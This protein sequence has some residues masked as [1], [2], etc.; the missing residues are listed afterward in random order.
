MEGQGAIH[1]DHKDYEVARGA[2]VYLGPSE[3]ATFRAA[4]GAS[5]KLFH[6]VVAQIPR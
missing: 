6:L 5:M 1:L 4:E 3:G 2:G